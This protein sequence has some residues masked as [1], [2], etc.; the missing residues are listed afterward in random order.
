[1]GFFFNKIRCSYPTRTHSK[2]Y[3]HTLE[4]HLPTL[5]DF[6]DFDVDQTDLFLG[7]GDSSASQ[8]KEL[9]PN[10]ERTSTYGNQMTESIA[11]K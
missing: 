10:A 9:S 11:T 3:C 5:D 2:F 6:E 8:D 7:P 4:L 1:M